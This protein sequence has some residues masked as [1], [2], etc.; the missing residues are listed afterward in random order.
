MADIRLG[1]IGYGNIANTHLSFF[2]NHEIQ[3]AEVTAIFDIDKGKIEKA[4][5]KYKDKIK[6]FNNEDE[7]F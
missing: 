3:N 7:F 1:I 5:E 6:L 4:K 2:D